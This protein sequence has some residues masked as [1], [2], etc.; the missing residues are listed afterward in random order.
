[1]AVYIFYG[2]QER[3]LP[4]KSTPA[5]SL[6]AQNFSIASHWI[7]SLIYLLFTL[8]FLFNPSFVRSFVRIIVLGKY[9]LYT[10]ISTCIIVVKLG[11]NQI[12]SNRVRDD[13]HFPGC[14]PYPTSTGQWLSV[15]GRQ[16]NMRSHNVYAHSAIHIHIYTHTIY[17]YITIQLGIF[18]FSFSLYNNLR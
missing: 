12:K 6:I 1:M 5:H 16:R 9:Y 8:L 11:C 4:F 15:Q 3:S 13:F 17:K 18:Y 2:V 10:Y 7:K 14:S